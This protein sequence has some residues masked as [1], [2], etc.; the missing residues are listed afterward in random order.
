MKTF[1]FNICVLL[2]VCFLSTD[3][4]FAQPTIITLSKADT[5]SNLIVRD[6]TNATLM[7]LNADGG[8]CIFG[9]TSTGLIPATGAGSRLM[10]YP[11]KR[12]FRVGYV[13]ASRP[14]IWDDENIG[15]YSM[16]MGYNTC[17][18][19]NNSVAL[20][21]SDTASGD[22]S[23]AMGAVT[24]ASANYATAMGNIT[25]ASGGSS[26]AMGYHTIASAGSSTA[27]GIYTTA[28]G[29][30]STAMGN[31]TVASST[32]STAMGSYVKAEH[33]GSFFLGDLKYSYD[34]SSVANE[35]SMRFAGGYR[36]FTNAA[37]T[38]GAY[39][40]GGANAWSYYC[41]RNKKENFHP[42]D[43]EQI[44]TKIRT[45]PIAE[46]NYKGT[47]PN[48]KYI[49][50]VAQDFYSAF[51]LGGTDSLGINTL[52]IDGVNIAAIQALEKRTA[53]LQRANEKIAQLENQLMQQKAEQ[54]KINAIL[55]ER[56]EKLS[57]S[58]SSPI[59]NK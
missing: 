33:Q 20:G 8:F 12:A 57:V 10:W 49:G 43:G 48:V 44:L 14:T 26:T 9:N 38:A 30:Y 50:P 46:W 45:M 54:E 34:S 32:A 5:S 15:N 42:I 41:D 6:S 24:L 37:C 7:K 18:S 21:V 36:L 27:M 51:H 22:N 47:D 16:A 55:I 52:C 2:L 40:T 35:M 1:I 3:E 58:I 39:M 59:T 13:S 29:F 53:E 28:S 4:L 25:T 56:I 17:A 31:Y 19:G 11:Q 23:T